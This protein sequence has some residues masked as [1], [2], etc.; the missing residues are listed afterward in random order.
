MDIAE[1]ETSGLKSEIRP[2][3]NRVSETKME[4]K[5]TRSN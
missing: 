3:G 2:K 4:R 1:I 5:G